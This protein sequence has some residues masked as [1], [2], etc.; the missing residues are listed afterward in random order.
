METFKKYIDEV[1]DYL[2]LL[3]FWNW[4]EPFLNP[5]APEMIRYATDRGVL[6][7]SSTNGNV[8]FSTDLAERIVKSN[9]TSLIIAMDGATQETYAEY[10]IGGKLDMVMK[11]IQILQETKKRLNSPYPRITVRFVAMH[12]N[13][14]ER[15]KVEELAKE[16]GADFFAT[17]SVDMPIPVGEHLDEKYRPE[18]QTLRRYEY[19]A[20]TYKRKEQ[21]FTCMRPWKRITMDSSGEIISCE[22]DYKNSLTFGNINGEK[23]VMQTWK[24]AFSQQ[25]R[26]GF[27]LGHN[28]FYHCKV[29]T[30]KDLVG[31]DCILEA[32]PLK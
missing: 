5:D 15:K 29:C 1:G 28:E 20:G 21:P 13:E 14:S 9:L 2:L 19:V 27:S 12:H 22:Y 11:N 10:R 7:H 23:S 30:Y 32:H 31:N 4:G 24:S 18:D 17:K 25:F 16:L 8:P 26:K 6:V 3:I